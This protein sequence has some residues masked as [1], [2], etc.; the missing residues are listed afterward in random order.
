MTFLLRYIIYVLLHNEY[1][2][3][4]KTKLDEEGLIILSG[5]LIN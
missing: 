1:N 5:S 2:Q 3:Q 4:T